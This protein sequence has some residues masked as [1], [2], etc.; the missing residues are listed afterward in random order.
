MIIILLLWKNVIYSTKPHKIIW[1][2]E[3]SVLLHVGSEIVMTDNQG[4]VVW[5]HNIS[6]YKSVQSVLEMLIK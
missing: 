5:K 4:Y 2:S 1:V 3:E 6:G